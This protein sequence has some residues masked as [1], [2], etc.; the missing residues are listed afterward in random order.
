MPV[1][2]SCE[3]IETS[4]GTRFDDLASASHP[5]STAAK[6]AQP[7]RVLHHCIPDAHDPKLA[8]TARAVLRLRRMVFATITQ[9]LATFRAVEPHACSVN[10]NL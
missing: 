4:T 7:N 2:V 1:A 8:A 3:S 10:A 9:K 5:Q 6:A